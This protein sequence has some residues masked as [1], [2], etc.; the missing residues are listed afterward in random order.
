MARYH[1]YSWYLVLNGG[2]TRQQ[3]DHSER[4]IRRTR[5]KTTRNKALDTRVLLGLIARARGRDNRV[6]G[7]LLEKVR[8]FMTVLWLCSSGMN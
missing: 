1:L 4:C 8:Y 5:T 2:K 7:F 6:R 3:L